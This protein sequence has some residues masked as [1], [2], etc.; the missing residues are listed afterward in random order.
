[1][2]TAL[3]LLAATPAGDEPCVVAPGQCYTVEDWRR[4]EIP[5]GAC[6]RLGI[7]DVDSGAPIVEVAKILT[8][9]SCSPVPE[10][11]TRL[12]EIAKRAMAQIQKTRSLPVV[13]QKERLP[14]AK[15]ASVAVEIV[16]VVK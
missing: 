11:K 15:K 6:L 14:C 7:H 12:A 8:Q 9:P 13:F 1:M 10:E 3:L 4:C 2:L 16:R 5:V